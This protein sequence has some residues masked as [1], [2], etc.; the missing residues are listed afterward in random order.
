M[1]LE[2]PK[3]SVVFEQGVYEIRHYE[4]YIVAEVDVTATSDRR[5]GNKAFRILAGYIFGENMAC[6]ILAMR[7]P[8]VSTRGLGLNM[9][10][11]F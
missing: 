4:P 7:A 11:R 5:A 2:K 8:V 9:T 10:A 6:S 1:A 3:Y